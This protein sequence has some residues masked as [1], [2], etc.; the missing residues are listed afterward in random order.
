MFLSVAAITLGLIFLVWSANYFVDGSAAVSKYLNISPLIIGMIIVGFG[1]SAPEMLVSFISSLSG[2]SGIALGNAYGSNITNIALILGI[3]AMIS[4]IIVKSEILKKELPVLSFFTL[5]T[6]IMMLDKKIGFNDSL[7]LLGLFFVYLTYTIIMSFKQRDDSLV[8]EIEA[9]IENYNQ[10][11]KKS[12][13]KLVS[14]LLILIVS[15]RVLVWG[16]V[17]LATFFG[18]SDLIIGLTIVAI[19]TSLPELASTL[20]AARKGEHEL[21]LGNIIGSNIFNTMVVIGIAGLVHDLDVDSMIISRDI[22]IMTI[23]TF[24]IFIIGYGFKGKQGIIN[25]YEGMAI[26]SVYVFYILLLII[27]V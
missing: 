11:I 24:S 9:G 8:H 26:F 2:N 20:V 22:L 14:G 7:I 18:V 10:P 17:E 6:I 3:S 27:S 5:V 23:L 13:I 15:S 25:R 19:G 21:A 16:A 4:P 12:I 1:T